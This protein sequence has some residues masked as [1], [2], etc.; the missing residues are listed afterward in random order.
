MCGVNRL[1]YCLRAV[2][3]A[4]WFGRG[5]ETRQE[6]S[7]VSEESRDLG[8][9]LICVCVSDEAEDEKDNI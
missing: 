1:H 4:G 6:V 9:N 8:V 5:V 2:A 3:K 7:K